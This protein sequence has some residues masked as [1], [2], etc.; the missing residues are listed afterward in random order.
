MK[1]SIVSSKLLAS[2][3]GMTYSIKF[4]ILYKDCFGP[5]DIDSESIQPLSVLHSV[6]KREW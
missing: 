2:H 5:S 3:Q 6:L 1:K 4:T